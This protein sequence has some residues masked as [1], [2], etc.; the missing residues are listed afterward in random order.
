M[1]YFV[2]GCCRISC[3]GEKVPISKDSETFYQKTQVGREKGLNNGEF[4]KIHVPSL[5]TFYFYRGN[6][7]KMHCTSSAKFLVILAFKKWRHRNRK[8]ILML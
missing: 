8:L 3:Y 1:T 5:L 4:R 7:E 6:S 2:Q